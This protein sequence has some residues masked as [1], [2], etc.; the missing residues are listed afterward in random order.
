MNWRPF[1]TA[2]RDGSEFLAAFALIDDYTYDVL[3]LED[4]AWRNRE[5]LIFDDFH[6]WCEI[7]PPGQPAQ[8]A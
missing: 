4:N 2:P 3:T 1:D 8:D 7:T 6:Y 5:G